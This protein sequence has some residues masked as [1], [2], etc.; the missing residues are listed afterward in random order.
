[1]EGCG[2]AHPGIT[3]RGERPLA[4][5]WQSR[6]QVKIMMESKDD[7][8]VSREEVMIALKEK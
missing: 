3:R 4:R 5:T 2:Q 6:V 1:M 7:E 8:L